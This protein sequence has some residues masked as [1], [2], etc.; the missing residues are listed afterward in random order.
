MTN[1]TFKREVSVLRLGKALTL[2]FRK[3]HTTFTSWRWEKKRKGRRK[4]PYNKNLNSC[5]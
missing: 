5:I 2:P 4:A 1:K 3:F